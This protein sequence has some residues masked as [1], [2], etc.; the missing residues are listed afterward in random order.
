M[1][2]ANSS[3]N[4][5]VS[6]STNSE[7][8]KNKAGPRRE[9]FRPDGTVKIVNAHEPSPET[10]KGGTLSSRRPDL[11]GAIQ[12]VLA[13]K[14]CQAQK[15]GMRTGSSIPHFGIIIPDRST[16]QDQAIAICIATLGQTASDVLA[17]VATSELA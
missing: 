4:S 5:D 12:S 1:L 17:H 6:F 3:A 16:V 7:G 10:L 14:S 8:V 2:G 15:H 11:D 13:S 9:H